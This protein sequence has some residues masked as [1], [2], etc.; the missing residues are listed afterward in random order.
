MP[1]VAYTAGGFFLRPNRWVGYPDVV[2][3]KTITEDR[4]QMKNEEL[5]ETITIRMHPEMVRC[6]TIL[7]EKRGTSIGSEIRK[8]VKRHLSDGVRERS[9]SKSR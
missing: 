2:H 6:L 5:R 9:G 3:C 7:S 1:P 4:L 8:A